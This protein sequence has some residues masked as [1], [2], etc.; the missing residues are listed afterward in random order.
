MD[1]P[2]YGNGIRGI[3]AFWIQTYFYCRQEFFPSKEIRAQ[4]ALGTF[5]DIGTQT[6][7]V[8]HKLDK[9]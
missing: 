6:I 2:E 3:I 9:L 1:R 7:R 5:L 4:K 8:M